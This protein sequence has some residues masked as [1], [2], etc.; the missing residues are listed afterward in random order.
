MPIAILLGIDNLKHQAKKLKPD[1]IR[2]W[3]KIKRS[4]KSKC[5]PKLQPED[6]I[7]IDIRDLEPQEWDAIHDNN[8]KYY[9][10][11]MRKK[12][13]IQKIIDETIAHFKDYDGVYV[14]FDVDSMDPS[15]SIGTG[16][17]VPD[18]LSV[19]EA[20]MLL[21]SF[22]RMPNFK[23]L[24]VTEVNPLLDSQNKMATTV[25]KILR[26]S[27]SPEVIYAI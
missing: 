17:P 3:E 20:K 27:L 16:T 22:S 12:M 7:Y 10:P 9:T 19:D 2:N 18:G 6:I 4:G 8:I 24:E 15:I 21:K 11:E 23:S 26:D 25:V 5:S 1:V 14:S 13:G